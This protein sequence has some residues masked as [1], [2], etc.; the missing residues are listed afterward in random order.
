MSKCKWNSIAKKV[1][2]KEDIDFIGKKKATSIINSI[3]IDARQL[4]LYKEDVEYVS[5]N[6]RKILNELINKNWLYEA[7]T[8]RGRVY[9]IHPLKQ[10]RYFYFY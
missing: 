3:L 9:L 2:S 4:Y 1:L 7:I 8:N 5:D 10:L 6:Y